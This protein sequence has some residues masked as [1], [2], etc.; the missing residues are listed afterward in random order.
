MNIALGAALVFGIVSFAMTVFRDIGLS[1]ILN[2]DAFLIVAGGT[3]VGLLVGFPVQ[4]LRTAL[5][6]VAGTFRK[7]RE[8]ETVIQEIIE[9]ARSSRKVNVRH[10][11]EKIQNMDDDFLRFGAGLLIYGHDARE[12][13]NIMEKEM[14]IRKMNCNFSRNVLKTV[15][16]LTPSF[17]L[18]GTVISLIKMFRNLE[19][20]ESVAPLMAVALMSTFYGVIIANLFMLPL[21]TKLEEHSIVSASLMNMT[22]EGI[23][24]IKS[25]EH[26]LRIEDRLR[27]F[28]DK[29]SA[30]L[31]D[32]GLPQMIHGAAEAIYR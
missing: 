11:E 31:E 14:M 20:V 17:G 5:H 24:L 21:C 1:M 23:L 3:T 4:R 7:Q 16:R 32:I 15:A 9:V 18:A 22:I 10:L 30:L 26:P 2:I 8:R 27:G 29:D 25:G 28:E 13:K 12:I 6:D 19:S